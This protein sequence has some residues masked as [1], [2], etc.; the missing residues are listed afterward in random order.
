M[1]ITAAD[2]GRTEKRVFIFYALAVFA[3]L[4]AVHRFIFL[5][6]DDF[7]YGAF[8]RRGFSGFWRSHFEHY[9]TVNGRGIVHFL[10]SL[11]LVSGAEIWRIL[12]PVLI[13][14][15][16]WLISKA[17][18]GRADPAGFITAVSVMLTLP[19][20]TARES[21]YWLDGSMNYLFPMAGVLFCYIIFSKN[22]EN[23]NNPKF[24]PMICFFCAAATEQA[25]AALIW[26]LSAQTFLHRPAGEKIPG[27]FYFSII[28][29]ILG[30]S[31]VIFAPGTFVRAAHREGGGFSFEGL[32]DVYS[33]FVTGRAAALANCL[34]LLCCCYC[35][36]RFFSETKKTVLKYLYVFSGVLSVLLSCFFAVLFTGFDI[37]AAA[38]AGEPVKVLVLVFYVLLPGFAFMRLALS[39][40]REAKPLL[41][42][43]AALGM[44]VMLAVSPLLRERAF[45][46]SVIALA[47]AVCYFIP[48]L[49]F[50]KRAALSIILGAAGVMT[51]ISAG[52]G[53]YGNYAANVE[54]LS[55]IRE[56]RET[57]GTGVLTLVRL[58]DE[59]YGFNAQ[60]IS[61]IHLNSLKEYY[62]LNNSKVVMESLSGA[63]NR[64]FIDGAEIAFNWEP[65]IENGVFLVPVGELG[66]ELGYAASWNDLDQTVLLTGNSVR[67]DI[68]IGKREI[69]INGIA[70]V[71][72]HPVI[73]R[74]FR[75]WL[76]VEALA[77]AFGYGVNIRENELGG[78]DAVVFN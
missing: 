12:S 33:F 63:L 70:E 25:G 24:L 72:D 26:L 28:S 65:V 20:E 34:V 36:L 69:Y 60:Y 49:H 22:L 53:Y 43:C 67:V 8:L 1:T 11:M 39:K 50:K 66:A 32:Y 13:L 54:N 3:G 9:M 17:P 29:A 37:A 52:T 23:G 5:Y 35:F 14:C 10:V 6:G 2:M 61:N 47:A 55:R 73:L 58:P 45:V 56:S 42:F 18:S 46:P 21:I 15:L 16:A 4:I 62:R 48:K 68:Q 57:N 78:Y 30:Y 64:V 71:L 40:T 76:P 31:S 75:T 51:L 77:R 74:H 41:F 38:M 19:I 7:Y 27:V 44:Q 59:R